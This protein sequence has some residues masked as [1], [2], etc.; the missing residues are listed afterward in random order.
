M[1][2]AYSDLAPRELEAFGFAR[3]RDVAFNAVRELWK[4]RRDQG[5]TQRDLAAKIG[6]DPAWI[7]R[8]LQGPGNWTL[9]TIGAFVVALNGEIEIKIHDLDGASNH[10]MNYS[11]A[12][13]EYPIDNPPAGAARQDGNYGNQF[14]GEPSQRPL[15]LGTPSP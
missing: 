7:S 15:G 8:K 14:I 2:F 1:T 5:M 12:Y 11:G 13:E 10:R 4:R 9:R 3:A 6:R